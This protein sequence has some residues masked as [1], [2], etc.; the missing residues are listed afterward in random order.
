MNGFVK[1]NNLVVVGKFNH[2]AIQSVGQ[3]HI[4]IIYIVKVNQNHRT[5][6]PVDFIFK[7]KS[8]KQCFI[9]AVDFAQGRCE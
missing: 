2:V 7:P 1:G 3:T 5:W 4:P 8:L 6:L 9:A